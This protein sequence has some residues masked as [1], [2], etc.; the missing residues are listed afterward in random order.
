MRKRRKKT[1]EE[2]AALAE[3]EVRSAANLARLRE[4]VERGFAELRE[5]RAAAERGEVV[6]DPAWRPPPPT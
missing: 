2:R 6:L 3:F 4:L 1:P 5:K